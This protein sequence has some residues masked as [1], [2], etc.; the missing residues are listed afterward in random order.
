MTLL[1]LAACSNGDSGPKAGIKIGV[2]MP[3]SGTEGRA[4]IP[5]ANGVRF[6]VRQHPTLDGFNV[7][8]SVLDDSVKGVHDA[9]LGANNINAFVNDPLVMGVIGPFDSNVARAA[10][11]PANQARLA[12]IS[13]SASDQCLTKPAFVPAGL[14]PFHQA[15]ACNEVS[16]PMPADLRPDK[17]NTFFRLATPDDLQGAAAADYGYTNLH[18]LRAAVIADHEAYGQALASGFRT[19]FN[20]L[21]GLVVLYQ[22]FV[23]AANLDLT[24]FFNQ[25]KKDGA[26]AVYFG[27]VTANH[28][29]S[30]RTQMAAVF[31]AA[32]PYIGGD[33]IAEDPVCVRDAG[34]SAPGIFGTVPAIDPEQSPDAKSAIAAFK[35]AYPRPADYGPYTMLAYDATA[36]LYDAID[37][38]IKDA[39]GKLPAR[40]D[41]VTRLAAT[42]AFAGVT[43]TF[44]F[45][46]AGDTTHR[47][48]SIYEAKTSDPAAAW[49]W[50]GAVDYSAKLPY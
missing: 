26:Q 23:P 47:V 25:A 24:A 30:I 8:A 44:G 9:K 49:P 16:L 50:V 45:D 34:S 22:D 4:G 48:V 13:P 29:C 46:A 15:V 21:G 7:A 40:A 2:D 5:T 35:V 6:F 39:G 3:L 10:I 17:V 12:M 38:A 41:V 27:G 19:R 28:G 18:L 36:V 20:K 31:G 42:T 33:G 37:R 32:A 11:P 1:P 43:G 14:S